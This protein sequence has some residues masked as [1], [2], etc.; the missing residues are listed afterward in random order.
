MVSSS[1][2]LTVILSV[3]P[4]NFNAHLL[5]VKVKEPLPSHKCVSGVNAKSLEI[6]G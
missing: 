2:Y 1:N 3:K 6:S 4:F 5:T